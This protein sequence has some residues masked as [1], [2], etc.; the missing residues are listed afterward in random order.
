[1]AGLLERMFSGEKRILNRLEKTADEVMALAD[2]MASLSDDELRGKTDEFK[3]RYQN[4]ESLDD[5]KVEAF[6]VARE[7]AK[8]TIGE[9]PYKVQIMG[10]AAM[11]EGDIAEM[12][13][14]EGKTLTSTMCVYLNALS[15]EGVHVVTVNEYLAQRD[16]EWMGQ[17]YR[18]LGLSVGFNARA[19]SAFQKRE[20]YACDI[21][22]TTNSELGFDYLRD[23]MVTDVKDRVMRGLHVAIG[24]ECGNYHKSAA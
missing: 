3:K 24:M 19:M 15:G 8:R 4:G 12:K 11:H 23:N 13:T 5:L 21:T 20:A 14:G 7:A 1:M 17:I 6:A 2:S 18:F 16:A 9:Y 22:Y 10:A